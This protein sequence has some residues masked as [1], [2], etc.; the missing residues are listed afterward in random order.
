MK[1]MKS[2]MLIEAIKETKVKIMLLVYKGDFETL[3]N[4]QSKVNTRY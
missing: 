3:N 4:E 2:V 1:T